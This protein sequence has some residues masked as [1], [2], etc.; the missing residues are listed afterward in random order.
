MATGSRRSS[1]SSG[2]RRA[3][4]ARS[5]P[6]SRIA[7]RPR[8]S[9]PTRCRSTGG[10]RSSRT[11]PSGGSGSSA[12]GRSITR[13]R[14]PSTRRLRTWRSTMRSRP[15]GS[16]SSSAAPGS[17][18]ARRCP[19]SSS[20]RRRLPARASAPRRSTTSS[21]R[22]ARM[23]SL[24][25]AT[26]TRPPSSTRTIGA[27]SSGHSS[28][29]KQARHSGRPRTVSGAP[30]RGTRPRSSGSRCRPE[31][32]NDGS[33]RAPLRCSNAGWRTKSATL[34]PEPISQTARAVLGLDEI[35]ELPATEAEAAIVARTR[36]YAA[37]QRKWMRRIPGLVTVRADRPA[38][39]VADAILEVARARE[40]LPARRAG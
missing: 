20:R 30:T 39:E 6:P 37:Y 36:R 28:W 7:S 18:C 16:P 17:T 3:G 38:E 1:R 22:T 31:S 26:G 2:R 25:S 13:R 35:A 11:S 29:P 14:L 8:S 4:R 12:S 32:S 21:G 24:P 10:S 23:P 33:R 40:R 15:A 27:G 34:S 5:P 19:R 9:R